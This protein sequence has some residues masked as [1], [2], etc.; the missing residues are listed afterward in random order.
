[1]GE[2]VVSIM[3]SA[4]K[5]GLVAY[6]DSYSE[7][8][9]ALDYLPLVLDASRMPALD[10]S[11]NV[12]AYGTVVREALSS[13]PAI[14]HELIG[15][16]GLNQ[17]EHLALKFL[18][19]APDAERFRWETLYSGPPAARF[20]AIS[21]MCTIS[22]VT[23]ARVGSGLRAFTY[24]LRMVAFLSAAGVKAEAEF[25]KITGQ[26][27][28]AEANNWPLECTVYIGEQQL[29]DKCRMRIASGDL[30]GKGITVEPIPTS[31]T[32]ITNF[33]RSAPIQFLHFFCHGMERAGV[34]GLLLATISDHDRN[35]ANGNAAASSIFLSADA[36]SDA[37]ALNASVWITVLNSCSG[38]AVIRQLYSMA[39][40]VARKGCPYTVGMAEP[41][42]T[43]AATAFSE[44]FYRELF[45]I[46]KSSL[47]NGADSPVQL[48][49]SSA[50]IAARKV[51]HDHCSVD[52]FGRWL[53]PLL[54]E[55]V[56][57]PLLVQALAPAMAKRIQDIA[58]SL[59]SMPS[60]TPM[61]VRE[62]VLLILDKAPAV[63]AKLRP[64]L[65]GA[66]A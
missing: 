54:Y 6:L 43:D 35:E 37:L 41:I 15:A 3:G 48:D 56:Q 32:E 59:R 42:D 28:A 14:A 23:P 49:L 39:L 27:V 45:A 63:P 12:T 11:D 50:V 40:N 16:F 13:H 60:D 44:S 22:R 10:T 61:E 24:P 57:Q 53:L 46:L 1:M 36:L 21:D 18:I 52:A 66:F 65:Y 55:R 33:L 62:Q 19:K 51:I 4:D 5:P 29:L 8:P 38:A 34:Q 7:H 9:N 20:L 2:T 26:I 58:R 47:A 25:G 30:Q 17:V 31:A 64:N